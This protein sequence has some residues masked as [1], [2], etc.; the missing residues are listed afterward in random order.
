MVFNNGLLHLVFKFYNMLYYL[1][2]IIFI[3]NNTLNYIVNVVS[4]LWKFL[5]NY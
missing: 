4:A 1:F 2:F 3:L 5:G